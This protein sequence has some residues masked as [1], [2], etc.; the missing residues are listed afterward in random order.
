MSSD[1][2]RESVFCH[3]LAEI[4]MLMNPLGQGLLQVRPEYGLMTVRVAVAV[5]LLVR[6]GWEKRPGQW[7]AFARDFPDPIGIGSYASFLF[8][9]FGDLVCPV[10]ILLGL[11]VRLAA[12]YA[13]SNIFVAWA[14]VHRFAFLGGTP[15]D[16]HGEVILLYLAGLLAL[17]L[18]GGGAFALGDLIFR[19]S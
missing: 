17:V 5:I 2:Q 18:G 3:P 7:T 8:A 12:L 4:Y 9:M 15:E 19:H 6:H 16:D 11:G 14:L 10:L 1:L 13:L